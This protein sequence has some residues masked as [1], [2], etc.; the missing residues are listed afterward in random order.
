L[1]EPVVFE[2][3]QIDP[4]TDQHWRRL[5]ITQTFER[6]LVESAAVLPG[7]RG[8]VRDH[9]GRNLK[10][11]AAKFWEMSFPQIL[12]DL[13]RRGVLSGDDT[14]GLAPDFADRLR[15][16]LDQ[17]ASES[18]HVSPT[19]GV[20]LEEIQLRAAERDAREKTTKK[21]STRSSTASRKNSSSAADVAPTV[22]RDSGESE[23]RARQRNAP[24]QRRETPANELFNSTRVN[25]LLDSL[26]AGSISHEQLGRKLKI[27]SHDLQRFLQVTHDLGLTRGG[28]DGEL[29]QLHWQGR[30]LART[31]TGDRRMAVIATVKSLREKAGELDV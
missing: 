4:L 24:A 8:Q 29:I 26:E 27:G 21:T 17:E 16:I 22:R 13:Q 14:L 6:L 3:S 25:R 30:E 12:R 20:T 28:A 15:E 9:A 31:S 5:G 7:E 10:G 18:S 2:P 19:P 23:T 11:G 1:T